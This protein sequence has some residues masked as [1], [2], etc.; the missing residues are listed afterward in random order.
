MRMPKTIICVD[1]RIRKTATRPIRSESSP[2][3]R[4]PTPL[5]TELTA[6]RVAPY[7]ASTIGSSEGLASPQTSCSSSDWKLTIEMPA[8]MLKKK[9]VQSSAN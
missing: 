7:S 8:A 5:K 1:S 4:R 6:I 2:Q 3:N 9:T